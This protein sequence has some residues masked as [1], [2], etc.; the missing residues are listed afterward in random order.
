MVEKR[1]YEKEL[2]V[3]HTKLNEK[4]NEEKIK[5]ESDTRPIGIAVEAGL[6][7]YTKHMSGRSCSK[8]ALVNTT[9]SSACKDKS[10]SCSENLEPLPLRQFAATDMIELDQETCDYVVTALGAARKL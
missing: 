3:F 9:D 2:K 1:R 8:T 5:M 6:S 7:R 4:K 10:P